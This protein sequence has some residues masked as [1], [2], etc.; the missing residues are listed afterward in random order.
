MDD[1]SSDDWVK[2]M[3]K[4]V[5]FDLDGV[6]IDA[7]DWHYEALNKSLN[8]FGLNISRDDHIVTYDGLPTKRK[9]EML[10]MDRGLPNKLHTFINKMKQVY[11]MELIFTQCKPTFHHE[12]ALSQL[13]KHNVRMAVCSNSIRK[14]LD[15]MVG[16][17]GLDRYFEFTLSN[18]DV[19][20]PKPDPE[21]YIKAIN[22]MGLTP[23]ECLIVEDNAN[24]IKAAEASGG[25]ILK[26][27][28]PKDVHWDNILT[29]AKKLGGLGN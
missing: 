1:K 20:K 12:Y 22:K 17:A 23:S 6:L 14:T 4:A 26:V 16:K 7:R 29:R 21:I 27:N 13:K 11:T 10:S 15:L 28:S 19:S 8:L 2:D 24:G 3:I 5:I 18:Q 9:L 25:H